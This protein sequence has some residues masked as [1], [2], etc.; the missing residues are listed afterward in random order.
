MCVI[1]AGPPIDALSAS[2]LFY[3]ISEIR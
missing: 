2:M 3:L 1:L